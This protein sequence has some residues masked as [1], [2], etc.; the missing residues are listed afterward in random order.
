MGTPGTTKVVF[1]IDRKCGSHDESAFAAIRLAVLKLLTHFA[2]KDGTVNEKMRWG[3]RIFD[4]TK[5][6]QM[7]KKRAI[8]LQYSY[9][10]FKYFEEHLEENV[11]RQGGK[12]RSKTWTHHHGNRSKDGSSGRDAPRSLG[13]ALEGVPDGDSAARARSSSSNNI[14]DDDSEVEDTSSAYALRYALQDVMHDFQWEEPDMCSPMKSSSRARSARH[15]RKKRENS[16]LSASRSR[17]SS[18]ISSLISDGRQKHRRKE[19][20]IFLAMQCPSSMQTLEELVG[21]A[22][23]L[24][25]AL[26]LRD[27]IISKEFLADF[28]GEQNGRLFWLNTNMVRTVK[29]L[30]Y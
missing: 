2:C 1:L 30:C 4:S 14:A 23:K 28:C 26:S 9:K 22:T 15:R 21:D 10:H 18:A 16:R 13:L 25:S 17:Q 8:W 11:P 20:M 7:Y 3:Y 29:R 27:T 19:K 6:C 24:N 5:E 12:T